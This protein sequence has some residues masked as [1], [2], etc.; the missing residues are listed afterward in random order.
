MSETTN[1]NG[2]KVEAD[3]KPV[4]FTFD[5]VDYTV[6]PEA[7]NDLELLEA[8]EDGKYITAI[9]S[10]LGADQWAQFKD[11][12]RNDAGRVSAD[13]TEAFLNALM[14]AVGQGNS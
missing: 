4:E 10:Y 11:S 3:P 9:R 7:A 2:Q 13:K 5:G 14:E 8:L 12:Q 1:T 6:D